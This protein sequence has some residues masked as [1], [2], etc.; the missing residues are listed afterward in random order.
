MLIPPEVWTK[1]D[2]TAEVVAFVVFPLVDTVLLPVYG[3]LVV[4]FFFI[5]NVL[6][7]TY[8]YHL[9]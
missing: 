5:L 9:N 6:K 8:A 4:P 7:K 1:V 2:G 3:V